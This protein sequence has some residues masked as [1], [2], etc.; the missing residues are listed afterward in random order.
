M[1]SAN[2]LTSN[3]ILGKEVPKLLERREKE[4]VR[5]IPVIVKPCAWTRVKW[6]SKIQARPKDGRPLS[7]GNDHQIESDLSELAE[8]I[9]KLIKLAEKKTSEVSETSEVCSV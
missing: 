6:L 7:A 5:V 3:F 1:I 9:A 2:F 8:E 4:G